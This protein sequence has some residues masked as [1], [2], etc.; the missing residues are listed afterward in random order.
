[1][2]PI[3]DWGIELRLCQS[4]K[5]DSTMY[6]S[7]RYCSHF[8]QNVAVIIFC[9]IS[10][11]WRCPNLRQFFSILFF[12]FCSIKVKGGFTNYVDK[13]RLAI[14]EMS[15]VCR[16]FPYFNRGWL[17]G[18]Q[19][20][21]QCQHSLWMTLTT[22]YPF[23]AYHCASQWKN[24]HGLKREPKLYIP[25]TLKLDLILWHTQLIVCG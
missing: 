4:Q 21:K 10:H 16:F 18:Q 15:I 11:S 24:S 23:Q 1:M 13:T 7:W 14:V 3:L 19:W 9:L 22:A 25:S 12:S 20:A 2:V 8:E 6:I 17:G 5:S